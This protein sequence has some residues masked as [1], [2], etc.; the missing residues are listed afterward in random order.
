MIV[1][2]FIIKQSNQIM[3]IFVFIVLYSSLYSTYL[4]TGL[5]AL[6]LFLL[7]KRDELSVPSGI[8]I[9]ASWGIPAFILGF[10]LIV[11]EP[12]RSENI[13]SAFFYGKS[14]VSLG[15][16]LICKAKDSGFF[17]CRFS[18]FL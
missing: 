4:W 16:N 2:N 9:I 7:K 13:D 18:T 10:L 6:S 14:Q 12:N 11:E 8:C 17:K 3:Q 1:W 5:I 15:I